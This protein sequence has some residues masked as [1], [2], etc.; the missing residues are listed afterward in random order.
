VAAR[1]R[2]AA[3]VFDL[4][5]TLVDSRT[6]IAIAANH[7]L[8]AHGYRAQTEEAIAAFV[9]D[10]AR[11]LVARA[12]GLA[13]DDARIDDLLRTFIEF[14]TQH[15]AGH[16][17]L[18]PGAL[19]A[20]DALE[21][22]PLAVCTNKPRQTTLPL[23]NAMRIA[24]RFRAIVAGGDTARQKPAPDPLLS[25]ATSMGVD[26]R[27]IVMV[28]DGPQ[29]VECARSAGARSVAVTFGFGSE[30]TLRAAGP[31]AIARSFPEAIEELKRLG[32][33]VSERT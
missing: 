26:V 11:A 25:V 28:G 30:E 16:T 20:L 1:L 4:D 29:D 15:A 21:G 3:V 12:T 2:P 23:L 7:A 10:G 6:D 19:E 24:E 18:M 17:R 5:G 32:L 27:A 33:E 22:I 13:R 14:Y 9:G 8:A 31:D